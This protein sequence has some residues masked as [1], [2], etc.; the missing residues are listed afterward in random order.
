MEKINRKPKEKIVSIINDNNMKKKAS[1][2]QSKA[3]SRPS[4]EASNTNRSK[5][6]KIPDASE[7]M[8]GIGIV[9]VEELSPNICNLEVRNSDCKT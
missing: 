1:D 3:L 9:N 7:K 6:N 8:K 4:S 2:R 5:D